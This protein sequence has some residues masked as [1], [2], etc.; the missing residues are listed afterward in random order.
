MAP[1]RLPNPF[2]ARLDPSHLFSSPLRAER[3]DVIQR[4]QRR[5]GFAFPAERTHRAIDVFK[6]VEV[7]VFQLSFAGGFGTTCPFMF[8]DAPARYGTNSGT[9]GNTLRL[10]DG[11]SLKRSHFL[12]LSE[13]S[14]RRPS[15]PLFPSAL[16]SSHLLHRHRHSLLPHPHFYPRSQAQHHARIQPLLHLRLRLLRLRLLSAQIL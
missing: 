2:A 10:T 7:V 15:R 11:G 6:P 14:P 1:S 4:S 8:A 5:S 9:A 3:R 12:L 16:S 13:G